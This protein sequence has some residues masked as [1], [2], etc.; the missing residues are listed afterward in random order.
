MLT[1]FCMGRVLKPNLEGKLDDNLNFFE[2][3]T[4]RGKYLLDSLLA[5]TAILGTSAYAFINGLNIPLDKFLEGDPK[6]ILY[7]AGAGALVLAAAEVEAKYHL[8]T[9]TMVQSHKRNLQKANFRDASGRVHVP[10]NPR[11]GGWLKTTTLATLVYTLAMPHNENFPLTN[12]KNRHSIRYS[13]NNLAANL[14]EVLNGVVPT[15]DTAASPKETSIDTTLKTKDIAKGFDPNTVVHA[16]IMRMTSTKEAKEQMTQA[17]AMYQKYKRIVQN[18]YNKNNLKSKGISYDTF[19]GL[20]ARESRFD[21]RIISP[22]GAGG[23]GQQMP[24]VAIEL[25]RKA[26]VYRGYQNNLSA[27]AHKL[28][29]K[30]R[31]S[32]D[33]LLRIDSRFNAEESIKMAAEWLS[34]I[35]DSHPDEDVGVSILRYNTLG[36]AVEFGKT[37]ASRVLKK[38]RSKITY[39]EM[40]PYLRDEGRMYYANILA[41]AAIMENPKLIRASKN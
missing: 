25:G 28:K 7:A 26:Y 21:S 17:Y 18:A 32:F 5:P 19:V 15:L 1:I 30:R 12:I 13:V 37:H 36:G 6:S 11:W 20:L 35:R 41:V 14:S 33:E 24:W 34:Y 8:I 39:W 27:Y 4:R 38:D 2:R 3:N 29:E 23:I 40:A 9:N 31:N 22:V 10:P 16:Q